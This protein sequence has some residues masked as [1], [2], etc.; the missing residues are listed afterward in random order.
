MAKL[1]DQL[2]ALTEMQRQEL[3]SEWERVY[4]QP[5]PTL[6]ADLIRLGVAYRLQEKAC[7]GLSRASLA[8]LNE[9]SAGR[10]T[11]KPGTRLV[12]SWNGRTIS[13][14]V[15]EDGFV[16]ED[17]LYPSLSAIAREVTGAHWS[18]P[19]FFGLRG[20]AANG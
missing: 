17:R 16:F 2:A 7:G 5:A 19:R 6:S 9:I 3:Q 13:V 10:P 4:K 14:E 11:I 12:R 15:G 20:Q 1:K 18:G 8:E